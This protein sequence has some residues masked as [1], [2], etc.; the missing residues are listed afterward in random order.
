MSGIMNKLGLG[1]H[2]NKNTHDVA[3]EAGHNHTASALNANNGT[4]TTT[5]TTT[6]NS[7][8]NNPSNLSASAVPNTSSLNSTNPT[9]GNS[10]L[11]NSTWTNSSVGTSSLSGSS[12]A[13]PY[14][15]ATNTS[16]TR[17]GAAY[18]GQSGMNQGLM[19]QQNMVNQRSGIS[20]QDA[21]T[22]SEEQL[23]VQKA[24]VPA[25]VAALD[26][27]VSVEHV[28]KAIPVQRERVVIEREPITCENLP[29]AMSGPAISEGHV[30][31]VLREDRVS[32]TK[33]TVP[34]E[35]IRL[36][37]QVETSTESVGAD[38]RKEHI[39]LTMHDN[40]KTDLRG[41]NYGTTGTR[42]SSLMNDKIDSRAGTSGLTNESLNT[43]DSRIANN[44]N[45][46]NV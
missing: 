16:S 10:A 31:T 24:S 9:L 2:D 38:L 8:M 44:T 35:R 23:R 41:S 18:T 15:S 42:N 11:N 32:A 21:M 45:T 5:T 37:K 20:D 33:E 1:H 4:T 25:G 36:A 29:K 26:K 3:R 14:G 22:R 27:T 7:L 17:T 46:R 40:S 12:L 39:D 30:E 13:A 43:R 6:N 28:E 19:S 34:V